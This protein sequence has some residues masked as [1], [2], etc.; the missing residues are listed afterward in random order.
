MKLSETKQESYVPVF[1]VCQ[2]TISLRSASQILGALLLIVRESIIQFYIRKLE[3]TKNNQ[4]SVNFCVSAESVQ[5]CIIP[6]ILKGTKGSVKTYA[7]IDSRSDS[8]L[9][10]RNLWEKVG[11]SGT[12]TSLSIR[13]MTGEQ[14][15]LSLKFTL[16]VYSLD[17]EHRVAV[18]EAFSV[19]SLPVDIRA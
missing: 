7:L 11:L 13:T 17:E 2:V 19:N 15:V 1:Y 10:N 5:L 16:V 9:M 14:D 3:L 12:L 18:P 6:T 4:T 8:N